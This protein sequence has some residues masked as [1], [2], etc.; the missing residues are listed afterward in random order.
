[1]LQRKKTL[2]PAFTEELSKVTARSGHFKN[3]KEKRWEDLL[4]PNYRDDLPSL[5]ESSWRPIF[6]IF[7][8]LVCFFIIFLRLF[9]LQVVKGSEMRQ[10]ADGNRVQ[11]K[12][13]HAPRGVIFDRNGKILAAN[14]PGFRLIDLQS[15]KV[16]YISREEALELEVKNSSSIANLEIDSIRFYPKG[17]ETAHVLGYLGEISADQLK[18]EKYKGYESGDL[19]GLAGVEQTF[20]ED[21]KGKDGGEIIEVDSKG[22]KIRTIRQILPIPGKNLILTIDSDLQHLAFTILKETTLKAGS[23]CAAAILE[24]PQT[25]EILTLISLPSFDSNIFTKNI[26]EDAIADILTKSD[27]P[28]LNRSIGGTYPPGSTFKI[29]SSLAALSSGKI[30][31]QTIFEDTGEIFIGPFKFSNWYFTQYGRKEG[32]V[33]LAKAIQRSNDIYF[34]RVGEL[35]GEKTLGD[36]AKKVGVGGIL[37]IDLPGEAAGLVPT[38]EWKQNSF[39]QVWYPGDTLHMVIGQGFILTTPLQ[40]LGFTSFIAADGIL[41]QPHLVLNVEPKILASKLIDIS[42]LNLIKKGLELVPQYGGTAWPFFTFPVKTA[43]KTGTAEYGDSKGKTHAWY[44]GY[45]PADDPKIAATVLI[46]GGGEGSSVAAPVVKEIFRW[47][48]SENKSKLIKDIGGVAT[49]SARTLGE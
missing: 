35:I 49:D 24:N 10:L 29:V 11:I 20:E 18:M 28:V 8:T 40:V 30:T 39:G 25:G 23:C 9:H 45:A 3:Q 48:L 19:I 42:D 46:E 22:K 41:Y 15:K 6:A 21:L 31:P 13:I 43:G 38:D 14:S 7:V 12:I 4:I 5:S 27:S 37:G 2:G 34:Y 17:E 33:D 1:M 32:S 36:W 26:N 16:K 44:S 47:F